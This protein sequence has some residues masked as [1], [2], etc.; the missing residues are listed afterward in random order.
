MNDPLG[1]FEEGQN[2]KDPLGL[3]SEQSE[4]GVA[5]AVGETALNLG[6][7]ILLT[8]IAGLRGLGRLATGKS[9]DEAVSGIEGVMEEAYQPRGERG[10]R[11][12]EKTAEVLNLPAEYGGKLGEAI[13]GNE[14]RLAGEILG[15][16]ATDLI[17]LGIAARGKFKK[18]PTIEPVNR[19][20]TAVESLRQETPAPTQE[21]I[22][23]LKATEGLDGQMALFDIPD[24]ARM[25]NPYEAVPG[26]WRIDENGIPV[27][28]DLSMEAANVQQPLQRSLWGEEL[29]PKSPQEN[30][31]PLTQAIDLIPDTPFKGDQREI[32]LSRLQ[33]EIPAP[34][35]LRGAMLEAET[36]FPVPKGQR[37]AINPKVFEEGFR[38]LFRVAEDLA[39]TAK[40]MGDSLNIEAWKNG[41]RVGAVK[42]E[43]TNKYDPAAV[44]D[45]FAP[46]VGVSKDYRGQG[47]AQKMYKAAADLGNDIVPSNRK[48]AEGAKMWKG[49]EKT[50]LSKGMKIPRGQRGA[51]KIDW[52]KKAETDTAVKAA[53]LEKLFPELTAVA[54]TPE[55][56]SAI[57]KSS[58]DVETRGMGSKAVAQFTKGML[59]EKFKTNNP[60]LKYTFDKFSAAVD[61]ATSR[62]N[63]VIRNEFLPSLRALSNQ[64]MAEIGKVMTEAM[65]LQKPLTPEFL[66]LHGFNEKQIKVAEQMKTIHEDNLKQ[67]NISREMAGK[68]PVSAY[69]AYL[70][71]MATGNFRKVIY[72]DVDGV[73][74]VVGIVGSDFRNQMNKRVEALL[75]A[76]PQYY[77][78]PERYTGIRKSKQES[79]KALQEALAIISDNNPN[80]AQFAKQMEEVMQS[81]AYGALGAAKHTM[82][83]KGVFGMEGSKPWLDDYQNA[84][85][86]F[87]AQIRYTQTMS[88]WAEYS[89]AMQDVS[90]VLSDPEVQAKQPNAVQ[91]AQDYIDNI[92]GQNP[93]VIGRSI[94]DMIGAIGQVTGVGPNIPKHLMKLGRNTVNSLFFTLNHAWMAV[95]TLQPFLVM[96]ETKAFLRARGLDVNLDPTG[97]ADLAAKGSYSSLKHITGWPETPFEKKMWQYAKEHGIDQTQL[98]EP[99]SAIRGGPGHWLGQTLKFGANSVE[100]VPRA[101]MFSTISHMLKDA[102][103]A[104]DPNLFKVSRELTDMAMTDYRHHEQM[105]ILRA[106]GPIQEM[107]ANLTSFK[108]NTMSRYALFAREM[109]K[110]R[111]QAFGTALIAAMTWAGIMG[112]PGFEEL[113]M[114]VT[115]VSKL[116]GSPTTLTK[117]I[118]D[119]GDQVNEKYK[120]VGDAFNVG[121]GA[122]WGVD[123][124]NRIGMPSAAPSLTGGAGKLV[125]VASAGYEAAKNPN[126]WNAKLLARQLAIPPLQPWMDNE[127]FTAKFPDGTELALDKQG[128]GSVIRNDADKLFKKWGFT[129][130]NEAKIK[131]QNYGVNVQ[132]GFFQDKQEK[133]RNNLQKIV[134]ANQGDVP[135]AQYQALADA[136]AAAQGDPES[137]G[138]LVENAQVAFRT[139]QRQRNILRNQGGGLGSAY[140]LQ[141]SY[142]KE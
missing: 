49:F 114:A 77:A 129:G 26:D 84:Q 79:T 123:L 8:P 136:W 22:P 120:G 30:A 23:D 53:G 10:Q 101:T 41:E 58:P 72:T 52:S 85:D 89:K 108:Q 51:L 24:E 48:T 76:N 130:V 107:A 17:P 60:V 11:Y 112:V 117:T 47:I 141:R 3:F 18:K 132:A 71:G 39:I 86:M 65:K 103:F 63:Q 46:M 94:E 4:Q 127:W 35:E 7:N 106:T 67:L 45:A 44:V 64:E 133:V 31:V 37:G 59:Y 19:A 122:F 118:Y 90:Q 119:L 5:S 138:K 134:A 75:A 95:N 110:G 131:A 93:S 109:G 105:P 113:D 56:V 82:A 54:D 91:M 27:K 66:R 102:G 12:A 124:H 50:G 104:N 38:K 14:G 36:P 97:W 81:E 6:T 28:V 121:I 73:P 21:L 29:P 74:T 42:F 92:L 68:K 128:R 61:A 83:K 142:T 80:F 125:D 126:E 13:A 40:G 115:Q 15:E 98:I 25:P 16:F 2:D 55:Q 99:P 33:G 20:E 88:Q 116:M 96:P 62:F 78:S 140:Q 1:L 69:E 100:S 87:N 137:F 9:L 111:S 32:A 70:A 43:K 139:T 34:G 135:K 57:A